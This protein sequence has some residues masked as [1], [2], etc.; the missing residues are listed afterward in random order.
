MLFAFAWPNGVVHW[1]RISLNCILRWNL[2]LRHQAPLIALTMTLADWISKRRSRSH[3][4]C[5]A[6]S[7]C[8]LLLL[9]CISAIVLTKMNAF[10]TIPP[11]L[12]LLLLLLLFPSDHHE[13]VQGS[14][15]WN[16]CG[17]SRHF[18]NCWCLWLFSI[19][20][21]FSK[22]CSFFVTSVALCELLWRRPR[23]WWARSELLFTNH[24]EIHRITTTTGLPACP[25]LHNTAIDRTNDGINWSTS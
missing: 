1:L 10:V 13:E 19:G 16:Q 4:G 12:L 2:T 17:T 11:L 23:L 15:Q 3:F 21:D 22:N 5:V 6:T 20:E 25:L 18:V 14:S 9:V 8:L 24:S 7:D